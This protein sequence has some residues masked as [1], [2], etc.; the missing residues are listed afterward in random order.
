MLPGDLLAYKPIGPFGLLIRVKTWHSIAHV[1]TYIGNGSSVASRDG[2]GVALYPLRLK[3]LAG[4]YRPVGPF[5]IEK[6]MN[7]FY[8]KANGQAYDWKGIIGFST[9]VKGGDSNKMFCSEF[10][11]RFYR[12]GGFEP[13]VAEEDAD[14]IAPFQLT[15]CSGLKRIWPADRAQK[16]VL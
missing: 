1:E 3:Q 15:I 10:S 2:V 16:Q 9:L 5:D 4:I 7:W 6:A 11:T 12:Q 8:R 14:K 13:F